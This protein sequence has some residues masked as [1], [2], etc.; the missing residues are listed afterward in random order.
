MGKKSQ[1]NGKGN[2]SRIGRSERGRYILGKIRKEE[3][4][5]LWRE[6]NI[7]LDRRKIRRILENL[8]HGLHFLMY[9]DRKN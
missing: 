2:S 1:N 9:V 3:E 8:W 4:G 6:E 5:F 7:K